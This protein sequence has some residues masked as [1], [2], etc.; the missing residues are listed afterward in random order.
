MQDKH[1]HLLLKFKPDRKGK[2]L[3]ADDDKFYLKIYADLID[4]LGHECVTAQN[5]LE[6]IE[7]IGSYLPDL[8]ITDILMPGLDGFE[9][10]KRIKQDPLTMHIPVL[11]V[12]ALSDMESK[13]AGFEQGADEFISKPINETE[14][15][16]RIKNM[17]KVKQ[18]EDFLLEHYRMI[19]GEVIDKSEQLKNAL[20]RTRKGYIESVYR[21][22]LAAEYRDNDTGRHI[23]RISLYSQLMARYLRLDEPMVEIIFFSSPMHDIGKIGI[24][25]RILLKPGQ[26]TP[27]EYEFMKTHTTIGAGILRESDSDILKE[28]HDVALTHHETWN[29]EG[30]PQGLKGEEIPLS[31][32]IVHISDIYDAI[33]SKRPYQKP[34]DHATTLEII[35]KL[36]PRFDPMIFR[37]FFE[38]HKEFE[39]LY[40][41]NKDL[42]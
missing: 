22:T 41:E 6:A 14:F 27:E 26:L 5:G 31:G 19:E 28:A 3:C 38:C 18:Y 20:E 23:K 34:A 8:I 21:L 24:P 33:R 12:S 40:E 39:R 16:L 1:H 37:A 9:V 29:G 2:I 4:K 36:E 15:S 35:R 42:V 10:A 17:L 7:K 25:D 11:I 30:Y 13:V 32:R